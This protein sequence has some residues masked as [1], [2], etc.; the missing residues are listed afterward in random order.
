MNLIFNTVRLLPW[1][2]LDEHKALLLRPEGRIRLT[3]AHKAAFG[4]RDNKHHLAQE[5]D[6]LS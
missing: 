2:S 4:R 5:A 3:G 6:G 1:E